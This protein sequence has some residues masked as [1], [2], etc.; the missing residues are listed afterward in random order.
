MLFNK[1]HIGHSSKGVQDCNT[2]G[3]RK[4]MSWPLC[5]LRLSVQ[6]FNQRCGTRK[7]SQKQSTAALLDQEHWNQNLGRL[8]IDYHIKESLQSRTSKKYALE[9]GSELSSRC[10][11]WDA[12]PQGEPKKNYYKKKQWGAIN[13]ATLLGDVG[14]GDVCGPTN[15][16][17]NISFESIQWRCWK[18]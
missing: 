18:D 12:P 5:L 6:K 3:M 8:K 4:K 7:G 16:S 2:W 11:G 17:G 1:I 10:S 14:L 13:W 15:H 9:S